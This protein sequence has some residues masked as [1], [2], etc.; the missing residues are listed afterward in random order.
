MKKIKK[1]TLFSLVFLC[2]F[3]SCFALSA[4][5]GGDKDIDNGIYVITGDDYRRLVK[6]DRNGAITEVSAYELKEAD[7]EYVSES[8]TYYAF[9]A[10]SEISLEK[11]RFSLSG[12]VDIINSIIL[13]NF[14]SF[15]AK[16]EKNEKAYYIERNT[17]DGES[18]FYAAIQ[19]KVSN[20]YT[21]SQLT[22]N[23]D[24]AA[25]SEA[26]ELENKLEKKKEIRILRKADTV[27]SIG[28]LTEADY[29][30]GIYEDKI[31]DSIE[32]AVGEK[33]YVVID[34]K[35]SNET[36]IN[37]TDTAEL[38]IYINPSA[39]LDYDVEVEA[40]PTTE[41]V[42]SSTNIRAKFRVHDGINEGK[43]FRFIISVSAENA[44]H[45]II[46]SNIY[47][48]GI[49]F[50]GG[51]KASGSVIIKDDI[52]LESKLEF[53]LSDNGEYYTV[54]GLGGELSDTVNIPSTYKGLPVKEIDSFVFMEAKH[55]KKVYLSEGLEKIGAS[56]FKNC[57]SLESIVIPESVTQIGSEAFYGCTADICCV[58]A[59]KPSGW[60]ES[61]APEGA[62]ITW[63]SDDIYILNDDGKSY[64]F[65][66]DGFSFTD[67][68]ILS[69]YKYL[70]VTAISDS[71]FFCNTALKTVYIPEGIKYIGRKAFYKLRINEI[72]IPASV[73]IIGR[74]AFFE[75]NSL[76]SVTFG[77][78]STLKTIGENSFSNCTALNEIIIPDSVEIIEYGAFES[79]SLKTVTFGNESMLKTV[80][81]SAFEYCTALESITVPSRVETVGKNA[82]N[83]CT[84]L[85]TAY[86]GEGLKTIGES[87]FMSCASLTEIILPDSLETLGKYAFSG[88]TLLETVTFNVNSSNTVISERAFE[89]CTSLTSISLGRQLKTVGNYAFSGCTELSGIVIPDS[90]TDIGASAFYLCS[91][92][93]EVTVGSGVKTVGNAAFSGCSGI[94]ALTLPDSITEIGESAFL[95]CVSL[96]EI[97]LPSSITAINYGTFAGCEEL[98]SINIPATVEYI[99]EEAF[100]GCRSLIS[101][102]FIGNSRL[103]I[104]GE[105]A[106]YN[107]SLLKNAVIPDSVQ[108]IEDSAF[109]GCTSL[110]SVT[111]GTG[112]QIIRYRAFYNCTALTE[113]NYRGSEQDFAAVTKGNEWDCYES[114][115]VSEK[116]GY[117]LKFIGQ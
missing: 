72:I 114:S 1:I 2:V 101:V 117:T 45:V 24:Y 56:A 19:F 6:T 37:D 99:R 81:E 107:C 75:C 63:S 42:S 111:L 7:V 27:S 65:T 54:T 30:S 110:L 89:N 51:H 106:F 93:T 76:A 44:G 9:I 88:C 83:G 95:N 60:S 105:K 50:Y 36:L 49:F 102:T 74:E 62:Y 13:P 33:C 14:G 92:L 103:L 86:F 8:G 64:S 18:A 61:F 91:G 4:C 22:V 20:D 84:A 10:S 67:V 71:A 40:L 82:F 85:E 26:E 35:L 41:Y 69:E 15:T 108:I 29:Q 48:Q 17:G 96:T 78:N 57:T 31:K 53:L 5:K 12:E 115:G 73:E 59:G 23:L 46:V 68:K 58:A 3:V 34:Y 109:D 77:D 25:D 55:I 47:G 70:P 52:E 38:E 79:T 113:I 87:A 16:Y 32:L 94:T 43:T 28:Y 112:I 90:V 98:E 97:A 116:I 66:A 80:D 11:A 39:S 100:S 21:S 104:I